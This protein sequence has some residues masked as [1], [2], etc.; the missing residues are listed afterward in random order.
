MKVVGVGSV[1]TFCGIA[2][3]MSG[4]GDPLFLQFKEARQSV[5]EPYERQ[6][7][8]KHHGER[9]V[10]GQRLMQSAS[11]IFLGW[12]TG[13]GDRHRQFYMRQLRDAKVT[14]LVETFDPARM[15]A[16]AGATGMA[17]ARAHARSG[18]AAMLSGYMGTS[19]SFDEALATFGE[20]YADQN[21]KDHAALVAAVRDGRIEARTG[22]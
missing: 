6:L 18:D 7:P 2:L 11:D 5:L 15:K 22:V 16:Y 10:I 9:V 12:F 3:M 17:L 20:R 1:G 13:S 14:P 21:E 8:I 19:K 4:S